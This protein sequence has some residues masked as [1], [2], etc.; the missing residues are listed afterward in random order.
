MGSEIDA[1][2]KHYADGGSLS[3]D[4][5]EVLLAEI[6]RLEERVGQYRQY[7]TGVAASLESRREYR[8][9]GEPKH[10]DRAE[11]NA[12]NARIADMVALAT[13]H[14]EERDRLKAELYEA[15]R[16]LDILCSP[17]TDAIEKALHAARAERQRIVEILESLSFEEDGTN[18]MV[19][20]KYALAAI[21]EEPHVSDTD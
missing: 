7:S 9:T 19:V 16:R 10:S 13:T 17:P 2:V 15:R 5:V 14:V 12:L 1:V 6:D 3:I 20:L 8:E 11:I 4:E 18:Y 21:E